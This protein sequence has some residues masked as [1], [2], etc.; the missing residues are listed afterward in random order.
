MAVA[1]A[2]QY[3][4]LHLTQCKHSTTQANLLI[5]YYYSFTSRNCTV[6]AGKRVNQQTIYQEITQTSY[7]VTTYTLI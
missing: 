2:E 6:L 5:F 7:N 1:S 4:N 3:A